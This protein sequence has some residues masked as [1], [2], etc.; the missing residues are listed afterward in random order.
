MFNKSKQI[1]F[2]KAFQRNLAE[3]FT[4]QLTLGPLTQ[5][6]VGLP[7][8]A[9]EKTV[10]ELD[11]MSGWYGIPV[12]PPNLDYFIVFD[13]FWKASGRTKHPARGLLWQDYVSICLQDLDEKISSYCTPIQ[14][15]YLERAQKD[16]DTAMDW[17]NYLDLLGEGVWLDNNPLLGIT[18]DTDWHMWRSN[19]SQEPP[20]QIQFLTNYQQHGWTNRRKLKI[21]LQYGNSPNQLFE[22]Q[23]ED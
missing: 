4:Y 20:R 19:S 11:R 3:L 10:N 6:F 5:E 1:D 17:S 18:S 9:Y 14:E 7:S 13:A 15:R 23:E 21:F 16:F 8:K 12:P 2:R 22:I